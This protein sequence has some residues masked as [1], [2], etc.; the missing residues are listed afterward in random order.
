MDRQ[1]QNLEYIRKMRLM[2]DEFMSK[3]FDDD[4]ESTEHILKI[5]LQREDIHVL[6]VK[7]QF[8]VHSLEGHSV[9][10]DILAKD[11]NGVLFNV[12]IQ[13]ADEGAGQKRA[14]YYSGL[15]DS[16][17][18][19]KGEDYNA[20]ADTYVIFIT[21]H[22]VLKEGKA[23]YHVERMIDGQK[24]F[25]DGSHIVYVNGSYR[26]N[27]AIG[28]LMH[29]FSCTSS[30]DIKDPLLQRRAKYFKETTEGVASVS[31]L[32]EQMRNEQ[33]VQDATE[34]VKKLMNKIKISA[35]EA[36]ELLEIP[37]TYREA[38]LAALK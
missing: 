34:Y 13:R 23:V 18:L 6:S 12:E 29:D 25:G 20:L 2:D 37:D 1:E 33:A 24:P 14:R 19:G 32:M 9:R 15:L 26:G 31:R 5:I 8:S 27:T 28:D 30:D 17:A 35:E 22:D 3:V 21:E 38:V 16:M 4:P 7:T 10:L 11:D 36:M